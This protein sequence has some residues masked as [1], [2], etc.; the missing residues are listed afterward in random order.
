M[1]PFPN[2]LPAVGTASAATDLANHLGAIVQAADGK[3]YRLVKATN[4]I[5]AAAR[6]FLVSAVSSG[7]PTWSCD[8]LGTAAN[9]YIQKIRVLV[10]AGQTGSTGTTGL[11]AGDY[12][13]AQV[14]GPATALCAAALAAGGSHVL[15]VNTLGQLKVAT[16]TTLV[17]GLSSPAFTTHTANTTAAGATVGVVLRRV[18]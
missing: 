5:A 15:V 1:T 8:I 16:L 17:T 11:V 3:V 14:E 13:L 4:A 18:S 7:Q 9:A 6:K 10:P 12:F 2:F